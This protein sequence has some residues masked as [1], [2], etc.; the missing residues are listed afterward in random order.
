MGA[1]GRCTV[2]GNFWT[3]KRTADCPS[4]ATFEWSFDGS[5]LS[6]RPVG[7]D[8]CDP[9]REATDGQSFTVQK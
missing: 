5:R 8:A 4:A 6:F 7:E 3:E 9:R 2:T 1:E